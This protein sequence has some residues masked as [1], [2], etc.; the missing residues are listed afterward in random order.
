MTDDVS[1]AILKMS[2]EGELQ[3]IQNSWFMKSVEC[4][5]D[6][7]SASNSVQSTQLGI[8]SFWGLFL[9][10]AGASSVCALL[11]LIGLLKKYR[12]YREQEG[13]RTSADETAVCFVQ[14]LKQFLIFADM[15][16]SKQLERSKGDGEEEEEEQIGSCSNNKDRRCSRCCCC[17]RRGKDVATSFGSPSSPSA[18]PSPSIS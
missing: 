13:A 8:W 10:S 2:E 16:S 1:Q 6:T 9:I 5:E 3:R 11:H 15:V 18:S 14:H 17:R 7:L 4:E 12:T